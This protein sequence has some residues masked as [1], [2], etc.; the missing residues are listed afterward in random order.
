M[1]ARD[2]SESEEAK[3][4]E[5]EGIEG[6]EDKGKNINLKPIRNLKDY[7]DI[8]QSSLVH[9]VKILYKNSFL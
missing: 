8:L 1:N 5:T 3:A 2:A 9:L 4:T 7:Q 6:D